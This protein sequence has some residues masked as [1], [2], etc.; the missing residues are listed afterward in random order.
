MQEERELPAG[1]FPG[2]YRCKK[3]GERIG[4][5][6]FGFA[7]EAEVWKERHFPQPRPRCRTIRVGS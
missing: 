5:P 3:S 2:I 7:E 4:F 6:I 1:S